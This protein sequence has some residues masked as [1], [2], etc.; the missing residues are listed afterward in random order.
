MHADHHGG[1]YRLLELRARLMGPQRATPLLIVGPM[2][3]FNVLRS[4]QKMV[5]VQWSLALVVHAKQ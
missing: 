5:R 2:P 3:L 1:L 4:Y